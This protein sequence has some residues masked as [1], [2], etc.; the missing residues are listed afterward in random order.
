M[1]PFYEAD[2]QCDCI[3]KAKYEVK[4]LS[5]DDGHQCHRGKSDGAG[6]GHIY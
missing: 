3:I 4:S 5:R 2:I 1:R 6:L